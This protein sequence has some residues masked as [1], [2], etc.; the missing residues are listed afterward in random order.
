MPS[1]RRT[2]HPTME[3]SPAEAQTMLVGLV[4]LN[5]EQLR[6]MGATR[7]RLTDMIAK[8]RDG[9]VVYSRFDPF[10]KWQSVGQMLAQLQQHPYIRADCEDLG[11]W[12]AADAIVSGYDVGA[13]PIVKR[14]GP[15]M[16]HIQ[17][18]MPR[19]GTIV[20]YARQAGMGWDEAEG[21]IMGWGT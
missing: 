21:E 7:P 5:V 11:A 15:H 18:R 14:T 16:L 3:L 20:D 17:T 19:Y 2:V 12:G 13:H 8:G 6:G 1:V 4:N 9:G 10:D